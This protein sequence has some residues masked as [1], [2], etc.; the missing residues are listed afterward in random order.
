MEITLSQAVEQAID[1]L[2]SLR[3]RLARR[4]MSNPRIR[5]AVMDELIAKLC[6]CPDCQV[7]GIAAQLGDTAN[8]DTLLKIDLDQLEKF[9]QL[10]IQYLPTILDMVL[11]YL[12]LIIGGLLMAIVVGF[13]NVA[14]AQTVCTPEGCYTVA[15]V[16]IASLGEFREQKTPVMH[17]PGHSILDRPIVPRFMRVVSRPTCAVSHG[18]RAAS[19]RRAQRVH[20]VQHRRGCH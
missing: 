8:A 2:P 13:G 3:Q 20:R 16:A 12:P 18:V 11:K 1:R 15:P 9:F 5:E 10:I 14:Q 4:R 6:D 17:L 19:V 7:M